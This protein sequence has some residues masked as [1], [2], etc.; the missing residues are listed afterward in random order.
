MAQSLCEIRVKSLTYF[1]QLGNCPGE[2]KVVIPFKCSYFL[3]WE[4]MHLSFLSDISRESNSHPTHS[5]AADCSALCPMVNCRRNST[6]LFK[7][8]GLKRLILQDRQI[9]K[10]HQKSTSFLTA[11]HHPGNYRCKQNS[12]REGKQCLSEC[13]QTIIFLCLIKLFFPLHIKLSI[14]GFLSI[15]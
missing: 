4:P 14:K 3:L 9:S 2:D 5:S 8:F 10:A 6:I 12:R 15:L 1:Q 7:C 13:L 11:Y